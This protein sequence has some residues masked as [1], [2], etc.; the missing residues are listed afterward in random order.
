LFEKGGEEFLCPFE[1]IRVPWCALV[2]E[3]RSLVG[4]AFKEG[5]IAIGVH[6]KLV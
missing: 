5:L 4:G 6:Y 2:A 3:L 1:C